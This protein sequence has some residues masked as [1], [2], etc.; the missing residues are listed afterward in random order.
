MLSLGV[1]I[2]ERGLSAVELLLKGSSLELKAAYN[3]PFES[4]QASPEKKR[5]M[6]V[7]RLQELRQKFKGENV[8][9]CFGLPQSQTSCF[10]LD[11]P[12]KEKFKILKTLP[13]EIEDKSPFQSEKTFFDARITKITEQGRSRALCFAA[14]EESVG[15]FL[16]LL[17]A[18]GTPLHL[19]TTDGS[20]LA[21]L[22]EGGK[23]C[24]LSPASRK[25]GKSALYIYLGLWE[26]AALFFK[27]GCL[28]AISAIEWGITS[29]V[30]K[31]EARYHLPFD[32]ALEE[33]FEKS[34]ILTEQK[35]FTKEQI[36][37]SRLIKSELS[38]LTPKLR[39]LELS[40][41]TQNSA[42]IPEG[43]I[44][45]PGSAIKNLSAFLSEELSMNFF[46]AEDLPRFPQMDLAD[47]KN[48][49]FLI[50]FGLAMEGLKKAPY[51]GVNLL[52]SLKTGGFS[53]FPKPARP[54]LM[55][56]AAALVIFTAYSFVRE[57]GSRHLADQIHSVFVNYG[58]K[59]AFMKEREIDV[60]SVKSFLEEREA[61][62]QNESFIKERISGPNPMD[63]LQTLTKGIDPKPEWDMR[64]SYLK[65][66]GGKVD[67]AGEINKPYFENLKSRLKALAKGPL[68][69][70]SLPEKI[71]ER[72][73]Q[74]EKAA[75]EGDSPLPPSSS[76]NRF[77]LRRNKKGS[78]AREAK[79]AEGLNG[80]KA[81]G[82]PSGKDLLEAKAN[83][84]KPI[85]PIV[86]GVQK[87]GAAKAPANQQDGEKLIALKKP[88]DGA[89]DSGE[90]A[91][92]PAEEALA[93]SE[94][95]ERAGA[96]DPES[97]EN[98]RERF[99]FSFEL[100]E[101]L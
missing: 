43:I 5:V 40:F 44:F 80:G 69:A 7:Q 90:G 75:G 4:S 52:R 47:P 78:P 9:F 84:G 36:F 72:S 66:S 61:L 49:S 87:E 2:R 94:N 21:N 58:K 27:D 8:R 68:E 33:F 64:I 41:K 51:G 93:S 23:E 35:G 6:I 14:P 15:E 60:D 63:W 22:I 17:K 16:Q 39:L 86:S 99:S 50:P 48:H 57:R 74:S 3:L 88:Q 13:F 65:L 85:L 37:F 55:A 10:P 77:P 62:S 97:L 91:L 45:G 26:S 54:A 70:L 95:S 20:A 12:F 46:R 28:E 83:G 73:P 29:L 89:P 76:D 67:L 82:A 32:K 53:F 59:I 71:P 19:L 96:A 1:H 25:S 24:A 98:Q 38:V 100:R 81:G 31:M 42:E 56:F 101:N 30:S 79:A 18:S 92:P 11:F 34:F